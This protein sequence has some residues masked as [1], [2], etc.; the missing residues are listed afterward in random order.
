MLVNQ[1]LYMKNKTKGKKRLKKKRVRN[2][3]GPA[4]LTCELFSKATF[5]YMLVM[6]IVWIQATELHAFPQHAKAVIFLYN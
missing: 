2:R 4:V 6:G 5:N 1:S 3:A